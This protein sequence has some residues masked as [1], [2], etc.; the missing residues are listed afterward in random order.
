MTAAISLT[1]ISIIWRFLLRASLF[2]ESCPCSFLVP[3]S[4]VLRLIAVSGFLI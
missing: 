1:F 3:R 4:Y 2:E